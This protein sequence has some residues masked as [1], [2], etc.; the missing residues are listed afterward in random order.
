MADPFTLRI[1]VPSG[2]PEGVRIV[3]R[4][5]WTG[6]GYVVPRDRWGEVKTRPDIAKPGIYILTGYETDEVGSDRLVAYIGQTDNLR[7]RIESHDLKKEFWDRAI[8]FV[9]TSDGL[10]RAHTTWLEWEL[11]KRAHSA[12]RCRVEN[13]VEPNEPMLMESEKADT[14]GFL[15]EI[16]RLLPIVGL[17]AFEIPSLIPPAAMAAAGLAPETRDVKDTIVVP[18]QREGFERAFLGQHAWWAIRVAQ[19]HRA[20]LRWIAA[21]QVLPVAAVTH[22]AEIAGFEPYGDG[23]KFKVVFK[24]RAIELARPIPFG[25]APPGS[26]QGP[27]YTTRSAIEGAESI[28]DLLR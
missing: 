17:H 5:N 2:D 13:R 6:R 22:L 7:S 16:I 1:F 8:L 24:D 21:Y 26:M 27:R 3:D 14:R 15:N 4:M 11:I 23:G 12:K 25:D 9:S 10:N 28:R 18:A 19:K 20:N